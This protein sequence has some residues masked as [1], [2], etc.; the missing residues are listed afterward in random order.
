MQKHVEGWFE[1]W[2]VGIASALVAGDGL[3][4]SGGLVVARAR[5]DAL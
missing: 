5:V 4:F 1:G 3:V 2:N